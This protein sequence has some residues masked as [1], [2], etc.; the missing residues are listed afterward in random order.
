MRTHL[1]TIRKTLGRK[2]V[3]NSEKKK[4]R[5]ELKKL[6]FTHECVC[7]RAHVPV[8]VCVCLYVCVCVHAP[9]CD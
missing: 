8:C 4:M 3:N 5:K 1:V 7:V 6:R 9:L 2:T